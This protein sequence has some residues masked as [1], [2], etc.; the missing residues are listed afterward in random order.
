MRQEKLKNLEKYGTK[1]GRSSKTL[2]A[3]ANEQAQPSLFKKKSEKSSLRPGKK[4]QCETCPTKFILEQAVATM[5]VTLHNI[6]RFNRVQSTD[7]GR[8]RRRLLPSV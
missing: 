6:F 4:K 1:L 8:G 5:T 2:A 3:E 7:G